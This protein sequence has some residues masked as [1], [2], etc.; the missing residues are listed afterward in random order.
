MIL[1]IWKVFHDWLIV[2]VDIDLSSHGHDLRGAEKNLQLYHQLSGR[3]GRTGKPSTVYF[4]TYNLNTKMISDITNKNP[5]IFLNKELEIRKLNDLPPFQ[6]FI[7]LIITGKKE[8]FLEQE[9]I[10]FKNFIMNSVEG[11]VLGPVSAPIFRIK[12]KFRARL[13][14]RGKKSLKVQNSLTKIIS[15]YKFPSGIKLTVDVD[16]INFN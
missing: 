2:V 1:K 10:K 15:K 7:A 14:I 6:R 5:D 11:K 12:R 13:L 16:P 9:A 4:Q 3:A 8:N